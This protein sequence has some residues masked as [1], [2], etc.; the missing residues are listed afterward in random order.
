M[1]VISLLSVVGGFFFCSFFDLEIAWDLEL[2][3]WNLRS[4]SDR[5]GS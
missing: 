2:G 1:L 3:I 5:Y 4:R